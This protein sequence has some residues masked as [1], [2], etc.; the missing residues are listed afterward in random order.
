MSPN[1]E[2]LN[3]SNPSLNHIHWSP[4]TLKRIFNKKISDRNIAGYNTE[5]I[6]SWLRDVKQIDS[7]KYYGYRPGAKYPSESK[8]LKNQPPQEILS[9]LNSHFPPESPDF[10]VEIQQKIY[11]SGKWELIFRGILSNREIN[12]IAVLKFQKGIK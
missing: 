11:K 10:F 5:E 7:F 4:E 3:F 2:R 1:T 6:E 8:G 12:K 9:F